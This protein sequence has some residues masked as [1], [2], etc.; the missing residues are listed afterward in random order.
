[1]I[2]CKNDKLFLNL[3]NVENFKNIKVNLIEIIVL[4]IKDWF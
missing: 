2:D 4:M 1:M 3:S